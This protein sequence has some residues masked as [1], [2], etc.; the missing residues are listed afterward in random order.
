MDNNKLLTIL[1]HYDKKLTD[2]QILIENRIDALNQKIKLIQ[3]R[4]F[5]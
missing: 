1:A 2:F 4:I 3:K 5:E